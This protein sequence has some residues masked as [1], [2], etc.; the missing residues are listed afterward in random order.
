MSRAAA[1]ARTAVAAGL[2]ASIS[3]ACSAG[4]A[5][6]TL[7]A[8]AA[9]ATTQPSSLV[10]IA[11]AAAALGEIESIANGNRGVAAIAAVA[12]GRAGAG[13]AA[14][15]Y[16]KLQRLAGRK[17]EVDAIKRDNATATTATAEVY[18]TRA[19]TADEQ[20]I[21]KE[22]I[23]PSRDRLRRSGVGE[24]I[25]KIVANQEPVGGRGSGGDVLVLGNGKGPRQDLALVIALAGSRHRRRPEDVIVGISDVKVRADDVATNPP[26]LSFDEVRDHELR[27]ARPCGT[28]LV[29]NR[30]NLQVRLRHDFKRNVVEEERPVGGRNGMECQRMLAR[31]QHD[32]LDRPVVDLAGACREVFVEDPFAV[33]HHLVWDIRIAAALL[34]LPR[35]LGAIL[36][37]VGEDLRRHILFLENRAIGTGN[38]GRAGVWLVCAGRSFDLRVVS[39]SRPAGRPGTRLEVA[40]DEKIVRQFVVALD[41]LA[42]IFASGLAGQGHSAISVRETVRDVERGLA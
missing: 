34:A 12:G 26:G 10:D 27:P 15:A 17:A 19:A 20:S 6:C 21:G 38:E 24:D 40:V 22:E 25:D 37:V 7:G 32:V 13:L 28:T 16:R 3:L 39:G 41:R 18:A 23:L 31:L 8:A 4:T 35:K 1:A 30:Q 29:G 14:R 42:L 9:G 5:I 33:K 2:C 36:A 11:A